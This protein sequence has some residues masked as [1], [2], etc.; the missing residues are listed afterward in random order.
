MTIQACIIAAILGL[1]LG[2][3]AILIFIA[4]VLIIID[5]VERWINKKKENTR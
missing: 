2:A 5:V 1:L 4:A 3:V